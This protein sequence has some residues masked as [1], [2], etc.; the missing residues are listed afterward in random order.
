VGTDHQQDRGT[1]VRCYKLI[2]YIT[3]SVGR[4]GHE[5]EQCRNDVI[6]R[7]FCLSQAKTVGCFT[8]PNSYST[9]WKYCSRV[10]RII[11]IADKKQTKEGWGNKEVWNE[12]I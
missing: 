3:K 6:V 8:H 1:L 12:N 10:Y 5:T 2:T 4:A 9:N 11:L 7:L